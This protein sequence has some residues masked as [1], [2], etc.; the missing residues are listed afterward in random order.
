MEVRYFTVNQLMACAY[1]PADVF[2]RSVVFVVYPATF[3]FTDHVTLAKKFCT[4][5]SRKKHSWQ[6]QQA[7]HGTTLDWLVHH[8]PPGID[9]SNL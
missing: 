2:N 8:T 3:R 1:L 9:G 7:H 6:R 5:I 4:S